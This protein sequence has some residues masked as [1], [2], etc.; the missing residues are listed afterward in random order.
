MG[1]TTAVGK[2]E[3]WLREWQDP[4]RNMKVSTEDANYQV[5]SR[6]FFFQ[7]IANFKRFSSENQYRYFRIVFLM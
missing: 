2:L 6:F 4:T 3:A 7:E 1:N 5:Y